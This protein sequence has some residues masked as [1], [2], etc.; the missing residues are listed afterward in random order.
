MFW[1][2]PPAPGPGLPTPAPPPAVA[3]PP[4]VG[5]GGKRK[6]LKKPPL[7]GRAK[8]GADDPDPP[9]PATIPPPENVYPPALTEPPVPITALP[10]LA[11]APCCRHSGQSMTSN[12][13]IP[14]S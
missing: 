12:G 7:R 14:I 9:G 10:P 4:P 6:P 8:R 1:M 13:A 11:T 2:L 5:V 3:A